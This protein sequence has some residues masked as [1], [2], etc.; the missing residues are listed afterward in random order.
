[1]DLVQLHDWCSSQRRQAR[2]GSWGR[3]QDRLRW[4]QQYYEVIGVNLNVVIEATCFT[5]YEFILKFTRQRNS[6]AERKR[7]EPISQ[8]LSTS[9]PVV[10]NLAAVYVLD[11][12]SKI[13]FYFY[14]L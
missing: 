9:G 8:L 10:S 13:S 2:E 6:G 7:T 12:N 3:G 14:L 11:P 1:M 4:S 5:D